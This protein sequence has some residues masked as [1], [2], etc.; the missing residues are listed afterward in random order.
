MGGQILGYNIHTEELTMMQRRIKLYGLFDGTHASNIVVT[1]SKEKPLLSR[2]M[3]MLLLHLLI[4][5]HEYWFCK[6]FWFFFMY[7]Y[8][9]PYDFVKV[10]FPVSV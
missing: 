5:M 9:L 6:P 10:E 2:V 4:L 3:I 1:F 8:M 7:L